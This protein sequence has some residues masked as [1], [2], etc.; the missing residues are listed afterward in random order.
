MLN[1]TL[2][3]M[4]Q[5]PSKTFQMGSDA[6]YPEERPAHK[7]TVDGFYIDKH[8]VTNAEFSIFASAT[9][10]IS[11]AERPLDPKLYPGA[12]EDMLKPGS[13]V[14]TIAAWTI[15]PHNLR[16]WWEYVPGANWQ[17]PEGPDSSITGRETDPV[18]HVAYEDALAYAAWA[19]KDLPTEA[20][21]ECAARGGLEGATYCWGDEFMPGG[22]WMANTWQ[23]EFPL[24]NLGEDG[25]AGRAPVGSFPANGYGIFDMAGNVWQW[26]KD[27]YAAGHP[28]DPSNAYSVPRNP[29]G[30]SRA[31]SFDLTQPGLPIPRKV[32]KGGSYL[33]APNYC[34]RYRP[35]ARYPQ[36][37]DATTSHV[38]FRCILRA[39]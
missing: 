17:H 25:F 38:G 3:A 5:V 12:H 13:A 4:V 11:V 18:V 16:D 2:D 1:G 27:W 14:F 28:H 21:W 32:I 30:V 31:L 22:K 29:R 26:T 23:G 10:Y 8:T 24:E 37:I 9:R 36:S 35:A 19:G 7:V 34:Q 6:H 33:C 15:R 39:A 20:E